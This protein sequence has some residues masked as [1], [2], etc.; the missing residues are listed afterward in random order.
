MATARFGSAPMKVG[1]FRYNKVWELWKNNG[2]GLANMGKG[3]AGAES[4]EWGLGRVCPH[5]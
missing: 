3:A 4:G 1:Y 5:A 2:G